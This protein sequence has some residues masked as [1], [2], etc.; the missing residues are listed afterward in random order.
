MKKL[1]LM[2]CICLVVGLLSG[3]VGTTVVYHENCTCPTEPV[4]GNEPTEETKPMPTDDVTDAEYVK[5]GLYI[6]TNLSGSTNATA[7]EAGKADYDVTLVA[8]TVDD[9]GVI[10]SCVIDSIG[11]SVAFDAAGVITSDVNAA[12]ATKNELGESYG[13]K[14][15]AGSKYEWNEQAA[16]V[17]EY[18]VGKTA[19]ELRSGAVTEAGKAKDADLATVATIYIGGYV[20]GILAAAEN[21][22]HLGAKSTD[23][24]KL[25]ALPSV[26]SSK[27]AEGENPGLAQ[28]DVD[29]TALTMEGDVITSCY[30]DSVQAKVAFDATGTVTTDLTAPVATKNQLGE[31]YGM[32]KYA[33]SAYE[34]NEQAAAFADYVTG[35]TAAE[36]EGIAV[37]EGTKPTEA[38]LAATVTIAVGGYKALVVKAAT[39]Q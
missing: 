19:D 14:A 35:L 5:T 27:S 37:D 9:G 2:L 32:K 15:Y 26:K 33:G 29:V 4:P 39:A 1:S 38:D 23:V 34:W 25:A 16:A 6:G 36:V 21:A 10:R 17:A 28:L 18:A 22:Q 3:C 30:I 31:N 7:E 13:M 8:V 20:E 11:T 12:I 24:L